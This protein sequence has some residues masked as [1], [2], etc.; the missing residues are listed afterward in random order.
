[1]LA[2]KTNWVEWLYIMLFMVAHKKNKLS[3]LALGTGSVLIL[4]TTISCFF[5]AGVG[6]GF[7]L[8]VEKIALHDLEGK[9]DYVSLEFCL[10]I[11]IVFIVDGFNNIHSHL[12]HPQGAITV[13]SF[14][15]L[16]KNNGQS[17]LMLEEFVDTDQTV[18]KDIHEF[19]KEIK[20]KYTYSEEEILG[21]YSRKAFKEFDKDGN[22]FISATE[23][24]RTD[25]EMIRTYLSS[26]DID[27]NG[28]IDYEEFVR[29]GN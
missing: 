24:F 21:A 18:I 16:F 29:F 28:Q 15:S 1:M 20:P 5:F 4:L 27:G 13:M 17:K 23:L 2:H 19:L 22:G 25:D 6:A 10:C 11:C 3:L 14:V 12:V 7:V 9:L 26:L 8:S